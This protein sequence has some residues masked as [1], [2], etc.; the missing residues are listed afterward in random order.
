MKKFYILLF[1]LFFINSYAQIV[2]VPDDVFEQSL[3]DQNIDSDGVLNDQI[4]MSDALSVTELDVSNPGIVSPSSRI[5]DLTGL[6]AF[7]NLTSLKVNYHN[8]A[9]INTSTLINLQVFECKSNYTLATLDF[10]TNTQITHLDFS[11]NIDLPSTLDVSNNSLLVELNFTSCGFT[12][13]DISTLSSL[14]ILRAGQNGLTSIDVT[15]NSQLNTLFIQNNVLTSLD[16]SNNLLLDDL[17]F[18][19]NNIASLNA[20]NNTVLSYLD[21][22]GNMLTSLEVSNNP[23]LTGLYINNNQLTTLDVT[24]LTA[25]DV[26]WGQ[27]NNIAF[28]DFSN[29]IVL[30][31]MYAQ[32]NA[33]TGVNLKNGNTSNITPAGFD[34][35][36]N[37][38][39]SFACVDDMAWAD[40]NLTNKEAGTAYTT[41]CT[42]STE[43]YQLNSGIRLYPNPAN[44]ILNI[45][46]K[47]SIDT[48]EVYT[49]N[50]RKILSSEFTNSLDV[51]PLSSG[52]YLMK[53]TAND[54][55][56]IKRLIIQ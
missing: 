33:L 45:E 17:R 3:I 7:T 47:E 39:L 4:L 44:S 37:I 11:S 15:S 8:V 12:N 35:R 21:C 40:A 43:D 14:E 5:Y 9:S 48:I 41:N 6:E 32:N 1:S 52:V 23:L 36:G 10:S 19:N 18:N 25:L 20:D 31:I 50:G 38:G 16:I 55:H 26:F 27:D 29:S 49:I 56:A 30:R 34:I 22:S 28:L 46:S 2:S 13:I 24:N 42:L 53:L 54:K 51:S